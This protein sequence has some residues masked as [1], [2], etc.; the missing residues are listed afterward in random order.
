MSDEDR[1]NWGCSKDASCGQGYG[2]GGPCVPIERGLGRNMA[3]GL[4]RAGQVLGLARDLAGLDRDLV[5]EHDH[6]PERPR[7]EPCR[8]CGRVLVLHD[9]G[10]ALVL[11]RDRAH[12]LAVHCRESERTQGLDQIAHDRDPV[13]IEPTLGMHSGPRQNLRSPCHGLVH[14]LAR[15]R[16][17]ARE[18]D[19][20]GRELGPGRGRGRAHL[21][22]A[23]GQV[24]IKR[25]QG[26]A[27]GLVLSRARP[28]LGPVLLARSRVDTR[29][30]RDR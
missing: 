15:G 2:H 23:R 4:V 5:Q 29:H 12:F 16:A 22:K 9:H 13:R 8:V 26:R 10:H 3:H 6:A 11:A 27:L 28:V 24:W 30:G 14:T 17:H 21:R 20:I 7:G 19:R 18:R 1:S 25:C